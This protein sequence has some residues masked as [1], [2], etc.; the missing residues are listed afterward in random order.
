MATT[1]FSCR[2]GPLQDK[3]AHNVTKIG[4]RA[5]STAFPYTECREAYLSLV[6]RGGIP[7]VVNSNSNKMATNRSKL[8]LG[9]VYSCP[10][11]S[12]AKIQIIIRL[13]ARKMTIFTTAF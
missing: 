12:G 10:S 5:A 3:V 8:R 1:L 9:A 2:G 13:T 6:F 4:E 7:I 11:V